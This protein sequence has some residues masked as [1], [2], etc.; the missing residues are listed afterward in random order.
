MSEKVAIIGSGLV[1]KSW[2]MIF[3]SAGYRVSL[4]DVD[5]AQVKKALENIKDE[6]V[7]F[8]KDGVLRGKL[9]AEAQ[10]QLISGS[11]DLSDC[12]TVTTSSL[13]IMTFYLAF[14][15]LGRCLCARM[16]ARSPGSKDKSL[17]PNRRSCQENRCTFGKLIFMHYSK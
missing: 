10:N 16:R 6:L 9:S 13:H 5:P 11:A 15:L 7:Q 3:A 4:F 14:F 1:G 8:E 12:I 17:E 2:A